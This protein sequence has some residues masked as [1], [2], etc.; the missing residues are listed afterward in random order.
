MFKKYVFMIENR[1]MA[2]KS[3]ACVK[4]LQRP[5]NI[6]KQQIFNKLHKK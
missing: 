2:I 6:K 5:K 1:L 4:K 3:G